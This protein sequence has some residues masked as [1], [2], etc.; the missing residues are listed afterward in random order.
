MK[1]RATDRLYNNGSI[2]DFRY[3]EPLSDRFTHKS[4][5]LSGL[6]G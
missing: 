6:I 1:I 5:P 3:D 2:L 4:D